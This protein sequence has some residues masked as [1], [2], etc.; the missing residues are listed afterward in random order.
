MQFSTTALLA[1]TLAAEAL[2]YP[3][4]AN[5]WKAAGPNDRRSPCPMVNSLANHGY[6]PRDGLNISLADLIVGFTDA[7]N[8]DPAATTLVG[9]KALTTSTTGNSA[10]FNLDDLRTHGVIEHDGSLSRNDIFF[11]DNYS[12]NKTI[13]GSVAAHFTNET[14]SIPTAAAARKARLAAAAAANPE[15]SLNADGT[16]FSFIETA[17]YLSVF[18]NINDGNAVTK[19]VRVLF[20]EERLPFCEGFVR[21]SEVITAAGILGLVNKVAVASA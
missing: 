16:Q 2:A 1:V 7:V 11:G 3:S 20:E 13:W 17:L 21:S 4:S 18:G 10:T 5:P 14:I 19:H 6:L 12:F 9:S 8:L 15:F